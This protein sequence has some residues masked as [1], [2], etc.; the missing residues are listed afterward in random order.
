V[1]DIPGFGTFHLAI[2]DPPWSYKNSGCRGAAADQYA[3]MT[4][5]EICGLPVP[6]L[7]AKDSVLLLWATWPNL[8]EA[9]RV[10]ASWDFTYITGFPWVKVTNVYRD[11]WDDVQIKVKYGVGFWARGTTEVVMIGRRGD[12]HPPDGGFIGLLSPNLRHSRKPDDL[13]AYA[14]S[15]PGPRIELFARRPRPGYT[16]WGKEAPR[17]ER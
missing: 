10:M 4:V 2:A 8:P 16:A 9:F 12:V 5:D 7:M 17:V 14:D 6:D 15:I 3:T 13:Y 1:K 11:L